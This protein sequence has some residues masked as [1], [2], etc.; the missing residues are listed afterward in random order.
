MA[1]G[2][3]IARKPSAT[4]SER[5]RQLEDLAGI[6]LSVPDEIDQLG[7][8]AA[9]RRGTAVQVNLGEEQLVVREL[10]VVA[11]P[12]EAD[13]PARPRG[14]DGLTSRRRRVERGSADVAG[15]LVEEPTGLAVLAHAI[16]TP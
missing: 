3:S 8:E 2:S 13:V 16:P 14:A 7:Q 12:D 6:D 9:H 1:R 11:D 15:H 10:D 5:Q 4:S